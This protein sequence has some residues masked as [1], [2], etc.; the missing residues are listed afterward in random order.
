MFHVEHGWQDCLGLLC[1]TWNIDAFTPNDQD[2]LVRMRKGQRCCPDDPRKSSCHRLKEI[3]GR[4]EQE[5]AFGLH[6]REGFAAGLLHFIDC[7]KR[8]GVKVQP[9]RL[10][11]PA[12]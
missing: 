1:S 12:M 11:P 2:A 3:L 5:I 10:N 8:D 7:A 4:E 6:L 9:E